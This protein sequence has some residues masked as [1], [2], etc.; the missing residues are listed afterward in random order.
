MVCGG[1]NGAHHGLIIEVECLGVCK[2][3]Y[4]K[5]SVCNQGTT[6]RYFF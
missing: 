3:I 6:V 1:G 2:A 4:E 5:A